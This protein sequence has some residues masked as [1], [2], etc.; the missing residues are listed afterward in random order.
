MTYSPEEITIDLTPPISKKYIK[1]Y[2][3]IDFSKPKIIKDK[4]NQSQVK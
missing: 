3:I 1:K 4:Q 2:N